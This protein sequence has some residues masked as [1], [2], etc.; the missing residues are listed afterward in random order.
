MYLCFG[1]FASI[2]A[3][4]QVDI[5]KEILTGRIAKCVDKDTNYVIRLNREETV[6]EWEFECDGPALSKL[7]NCGR[8]FVFG[9]GTPVNEPD[10]NPIIENVRNHVAPYIYEDKK[11]TALFALLDI[12]RRDQSLDAERKELFQ[13][14]MGLDKQQLLQQEE[15]SFSDFI[16]RVLVFTTYGDRNNI[17]GQEY[18]KSITPQYLDEVAC[19]YDSEYRWVQAEQVLSLTYISI[20]FLLNKAMESC[21]LVSFIE[22]VDPTNCMN[23]KWVEKCEEFLQMMQS[24][25]EA[26]PAPNGRN[27][28]GFTLKKTQEFCQ[29]LDDYT[30]Y[31]G[32]NMRPI[33]EK[34]ELFVP[35]YRDENTKRAF[36]F[37]GKVQA[38]RKRLETI[39]KEIKTHMPFAQID[40]Q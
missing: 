40:Y 15:I 20:F 26:L 30:R 28:Q 18:L 8:R 21:Q 29:V 1:T 36:S 5:R 12:V 3:L 35:L 37:V 6:D 25:V 16:S 24:G 13:K 9:N 31:L 17:A 10:I 23:I 39:Y 27:V 4:C 11:A 2:L 33:P 7:R 19:V 14:Y 22:K 32:F 34:P 38:Y